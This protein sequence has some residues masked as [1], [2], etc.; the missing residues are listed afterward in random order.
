MSHA[1]IMVV[2]SRKRVAQIVTAPA[3]RAINEFLST[4]GKNMKPDHP[5]LKAF[6]KEYRAT[7]KQAEVTNKNTLY[8]MAAAKA[9]TAYLKK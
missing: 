8:P 3:I 1:E 6:L 5:K 4:K 9:W 2:A 7:G